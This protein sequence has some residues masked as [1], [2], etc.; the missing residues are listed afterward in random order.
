MDKKIHLTIRFILLSLIGVSNLLCLTI[1]GQQKMFTL[2]SEKETG[3]DFEN[4]L[5]DTKDH[6]ILIYSNYY[7]GAGVGLG[8]FNNDG[9]QDIFFAGNL[10][11]LEGRF[12]LL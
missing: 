1:Q 7:G 3:I 6:N 11:H 4:T 12:L 10:L 8:D 9:L 2:L 5:I